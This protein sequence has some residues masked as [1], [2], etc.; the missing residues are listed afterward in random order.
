MIEDRERWNDAYEVYRTIT[1]ASTRHAVARTFT[2][3]RRADP[4]QD[5]GVTM[6]MALAQHGIAYQIKLSE[7]EE[8]L[9]AQDAYAA[10]EEG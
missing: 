10:I 3:I 4:K 9:A 7:Y 2:E 6:E 5:D 1:P 8:V